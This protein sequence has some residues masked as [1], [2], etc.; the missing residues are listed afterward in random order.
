MRAPAHSRSSRRQR[1]HPTQRQSPPQRQGAR[2]LSAVPRESLRCGRAADGVAARL[3][4]KVA[5][6]FDAAIR[7]LS[8]G[9]C[10]PCIGCSGRPIWEGAREGP[11][12]IG[13]G[14]PAAPPPDC[15]GDERVKRPP[16]NPGCNLEHLGDDDHL[17]R[18]ERWLE[19]H[20]MSKGAWMPQFVVCDRCRAH[21]MANS[22]YV[23]GARRSVLAD[24]RLYVLHTP[25][26]PCL[27]SGHPSRI[28]MPSMV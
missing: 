3:V 25:L 18:E 11:P 14:V 26:L 7:T 5:L 28:A 9:A 4:S 19:E 22:H 16:E 13:G 10:Q 1:V 24:H 8:Q 15:R 17:R 23:G 20:C 6:E 27:P 2:R 12:G 21:G